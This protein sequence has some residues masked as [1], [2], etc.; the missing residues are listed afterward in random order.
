MKNKKDATLTIRINQR[1]K[2]SLQIEA[3]KLGIS[4][5]TLVNNNLPI[6]PIK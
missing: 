3:E 5:S 6:N 1:A 2:K 4:L